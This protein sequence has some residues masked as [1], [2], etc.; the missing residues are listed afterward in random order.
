MEQTS[1]LRPVFQ[2]MLGHES[3]EWEAAAELSASLHRNAEGVA[4]DYCSGLVQFRTEREGAGLREHLCTAAYGVGRSWPPVQ[5]MDG[6]GLARLGK[7]EYHEVV[8]IEASFPRGPSAPADPRRRL[9]DPINVKSIL[10]KR[11]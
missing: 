11:Q 1:E 5:K 8:L 7:D 10:R 2:L 4:E 6:R 3:G 9:T